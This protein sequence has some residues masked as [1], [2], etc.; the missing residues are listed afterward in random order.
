MPAS[1]CGA[2]YHDKFIKRNYVNPLPP[3][4]PNSGTRIGY[5]ATGKQLID[6]LPYTSNMQ[7]I[8]Y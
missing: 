8:M 6:S 1:M 3:V 7:N 2:L 5:F 4:N